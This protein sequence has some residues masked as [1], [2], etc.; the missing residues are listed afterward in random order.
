MDRFEHATT[1]DDD[2]SAGD[3]DSAAG[4]RQAVLHTLEHACERVQT[5]LG[6][7][8]HALHPWVSFAIMPVFALANAGVALTAAVAAAWAARSRWA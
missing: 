3:G 7:M 5:P 8:E 2:D 6:R 1:A 4:E